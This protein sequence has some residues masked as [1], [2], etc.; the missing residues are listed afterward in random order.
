VRFRV[1]PAGQLLS[2]EV[3]QSSGSKALDEAAIAAVERAAP[4]PPMPQEIANEP[5]E[6]MVPYRFT[7][8]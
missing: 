7:I 8:R 5:I 6:M 4:F 1:G 2:S 3:Q